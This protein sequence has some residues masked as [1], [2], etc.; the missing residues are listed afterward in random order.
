M[1]D[2]TR[3]KEYLALHPQ[4]TLNILVLGTPGSGK[5]SV[6]SRLAIDVFP[7]DHDPT[8][9]GQYR[10]PIQLFPPEQGHVLLNWTT[11]LADAAE[12]NHGMLQQMVRE[13][14]AFMLVYRTSDRGTFD[15]IASLWQHHIAGK[16]EGPGFV[17][18]NGGGDDVISPRD[19]QATADSLGAAFWQ[20]SAKTGHGAAEKQLVA[21]ARTILLQ[22][23]QSVAE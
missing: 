12:I 4:P 21:M 16:V 11:I 3:L 2:E 1:E 6:C 7:V 9:N 22:R 15:G 23:L 20:L 18:A 10:R 8:E 5:R 14:D 19:G 17:V 13:A